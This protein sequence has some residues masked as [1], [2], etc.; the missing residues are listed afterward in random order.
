MG[1]WH[2][3]TLHCPL[4]LTRTTSSLSLSFS[5]NQKA[6]AE[7]QLEANKANINQS[8]EYF[9]RRGML[10]GQVGRGKRYKGKWK[11][12]GNSKCHKQW[13]RERQRELDA[14]TEG[15]NEVKIKRKWAYLI[16]H[17]SC[18]LTDRQS[19]TETAREREWDRKRERGRQT[20]ARTAAVA[21]S[22]FTFAS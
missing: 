12:A 17:E 14:E 4:A 10:T 8:F 2:Y 22:V 11:L 5:L 7:N 21:A 18:G 16:Y 9:W 3:L 6:K 1:N 19:S 20:L 13:S 15:R